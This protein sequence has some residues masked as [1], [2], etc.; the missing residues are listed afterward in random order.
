[1]LETLE[2]IF[3]IL[4]ITLTILMI[5]SEIRRRLKNLNKNKFVKKIE[6]MTKDE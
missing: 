5:D 6:E 3:V 4:M 2:I 1:M